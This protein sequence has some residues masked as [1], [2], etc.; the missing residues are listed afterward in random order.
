MAAPVV[1]RCC[2]VLP[3]LQPQRSLRPRVLGETPRAHIVPYA[4]SPIYGEA[5][6]LC[7][8]QLFSVHALLWRVYPSVRRASALILSFWQQYRAALRTLRNRVAEVNW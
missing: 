1:T 8:M 5:G 7:P 2:G 6:M 4:A 3:A